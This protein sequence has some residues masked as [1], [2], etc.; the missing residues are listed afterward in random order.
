MTREVL[1]EEY[2]DYLTDL[3][4]TAFINDEVKLAAE[5]DEALDCCAFYTGYPKFICF[6]DESEVI[7][8]N[9]GGD[10]ITLPVPF[11]TLTEL[12]IDDIVIDS[13]QYKPMIYNRHGLFSGI[14]MNTNYITIYPSMKVQLTGVFGRILNLTGYE[15]KLIFRLA[16]GL[17]GYDVKFNIYMN[18]GHVLKEVAGSESVTYKTNREVDQVNKV[19]SYFNDTKAILFKYKK[20]TVS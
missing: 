12:R 4:R 7:V 14:L 2:T 3:G 15:K 11:K 20:Y 9:Y 8:T 13:A 17:A 6:D 5:L 1:L 19:L 10:I 18:S 16:N